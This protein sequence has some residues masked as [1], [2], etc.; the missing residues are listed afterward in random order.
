MKMTN[1]EKELKALEEAI[2]YSDFTFPNEHLGVAD[3]FLIRLIINNTL[4][5]LSQQEIKLTL[6][7]MPFNIF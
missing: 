2:E 6:E 5:S 7:V 4:R 3:K 1:E